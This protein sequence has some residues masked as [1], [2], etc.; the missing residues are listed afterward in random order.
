MGG[1]GEGGAKLLPRT[2]HVFF[3][4]Y[5]VKSL[6][7]AFKSI[8]QTETERQPVGFLRSVSLNLASK[9]ESKCTEETF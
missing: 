3:P 9:R 4:E 5:A 1:M 7:P 2:E 8:P 6:T